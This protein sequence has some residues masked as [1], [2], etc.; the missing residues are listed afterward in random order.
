MKFPLIEMMK[1]FL[2]GLVDRNNTY[3][4]KRWNAMKIFDVM[5]ML[6]IADFI[7][8]NFVIHEY[9]FYGWITT[10][11][12]LLGITTFDKRIDARKEI[13]MEKAKKDLDLNVKLE[14]KETKNEN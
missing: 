8:N 3:S 12:A 9:L 13:E 1:N 14:T 10:G 7:F 2:K 11:L 5:L 6:T 4:M